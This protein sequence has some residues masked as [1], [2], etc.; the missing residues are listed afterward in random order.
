MSARHLLYP[1]ARIMRFP[2]PNEKVPWAA[3]FLIY[4]PPFYTAE[5]DVALTDP[6]GDTAEPLSKISYNVVDGPTDR[7]SFH[8]VY[9]VEYG[10]PL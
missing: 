6:V 4:D 10:F 2:V 3:E 8:G 5:K 7:R 9:V 1:N